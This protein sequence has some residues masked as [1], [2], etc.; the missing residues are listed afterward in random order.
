MLQPFLHE[1][2]L[3]NAMRGRGAADIAHADKKYF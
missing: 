2:A 1:Q 3:E